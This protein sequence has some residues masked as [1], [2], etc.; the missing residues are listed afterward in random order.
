[1]PGRRVELLV[2]P[3][4]RTHA[5][6]WPL[7]ASNRRESQRCAVTYALSR[8][9]LIGGACASRASAMRRATARGE[10]RAL[11]TALGAGGV[12]SVNLVG[13]R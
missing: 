13:L 5:P 8:H 2:W 12:F 7:L 4:T 11:A 9:P 3:A 6:S 1:M 10:P